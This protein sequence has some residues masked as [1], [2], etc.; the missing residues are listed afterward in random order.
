MGERLKPFQFHSVHSL[1]IGRDIRDPR[2]KGEV[3]DNMKM[4][5]RFE[6]YENH[7]I[8]NEKWNDSAVES[9]FSDQ[10]NLAFQQ[11]KYI[12]LERKF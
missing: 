6:G 11:S 4:Q 3:L 10:Y 8:F 7:A 5:A 2:V 12:E 1:F 9:I